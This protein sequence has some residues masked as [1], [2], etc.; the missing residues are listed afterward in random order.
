MNL[1]YNNFL[2]KNNLKIIMKRY[3]I[4][5]GVAIGFYGAL[6]LY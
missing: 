1:K 2:K 3:L 5:G 4:I 6:S